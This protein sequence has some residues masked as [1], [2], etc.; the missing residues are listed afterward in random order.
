MHLGEEDSLL[1]NLHPESAKVDPTQASPV[2]RGLIDCLRDLI[3]SNDAQSPKPTLIL[4]GDVLELALTTHNLAAMV[5]ERFLELAMPPGQE[6]FGNIIYIPGNH[7]HHLWESARETQYV[8]NYLAQKRPAEFLKV[9]WHTT[10]IFMEDDANPVPSFLLNGLLH[11]YEHLKDFTIN[12][13]YPNFGLMRGNRCVIFHHGHF[14]ESI[15]K[16]MTT[17]KNLIFPEQEQRYRMVWDLEAENFAWID[18]FWSTLG[19]S[20]E[21]GQDMEVVYEKMQNEEQFQK[22]LATL[23]ASLVEK[24]NITGLGGWIDSRVTKLIINGLI[25]RIVK[26]ER[27]QSGAVLSQ[28]ANNGLYYYVNFPLQEQITEECTRRRLL[29]PREV[30]FVFGHT[31][32]PFEEVR[33]FDAYLGDGV[34]VYNTGGWVV[35]TEEPAPLHGGAVALLNEDLDVASLRMYNEAD[36][37][38]NYQVRIHEVPPPGRNHSDLFLRLQ[39]LVQPTQP[40]WSRFS[41]TVVEEIRFR[42]EK[43]KDRIS[44]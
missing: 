25:N 3:S 22:L 20:G 29:F 4:L 15:Y 18:F 39:R 32:K 28:D 33:T 19:R 31:H 44:S 16:L 1:T 6:L 27:T 13:A 41:H 42:A 36:F 7:D 35:E 9:P 17:L 11:R 21:V 10:N 40:P 5:F 30:S 14:I 34:P 38:G 37:T 2:L 12:T 23:R 24:Y 26:R 8:L 43:L